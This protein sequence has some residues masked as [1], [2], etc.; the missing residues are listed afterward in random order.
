M[1]V[2]EVLFYTAKLEELHHFYGHTLGMIVSDVDATEEAFTLQ[3]GSTKMIF[4]QWNTAS[5]AGSR[6]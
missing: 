3:A 2:E 6:K 1:I 5:E 4:K